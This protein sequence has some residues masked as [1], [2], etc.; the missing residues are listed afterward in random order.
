[1]FNA[2]MALASEEYD[3]LNAGNVLPVPVT[4]TLT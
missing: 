3:E 4:V 1:V 2:V